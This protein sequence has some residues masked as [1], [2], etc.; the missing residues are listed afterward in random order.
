MSYGE[1]VCVFCGH[2][3]RSHVDERTHGIKKLSDDEKV[4]RVCD[5]CVEEKLDEL[6]AGEDCVDCAVTAEYAHVPLTVK[7]TAEGE[8]PY[9]V[10]DGDLT[11]VLC[12]EHFRELTG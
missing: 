10:R 7:R 2:T 9:I 11:P 5:S 4:G 3:V 8:A 6:P 1:S 12:S